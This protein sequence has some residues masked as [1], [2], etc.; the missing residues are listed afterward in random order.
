VLRLPVV[1]DWLRELPSVLPIAIVV[2][3][4]SDGTVLYANE[5]FG[6]LLAIG[7]EEAIGR[8]VVS[9]YDDPEE[10]AAV[11]LAVEREGQVVDREVRVRCADGRLVWVAVTV[12]PIRFAGEE[13]T[14]LT[15]IYDITR[16][17]RDEHLLT[18]QAAALAEMA[19]FPEMNP[20]PVCR[21]N[22]A[23][24]ILLANQATRHFFGE[25]KL[26]GR[27]WLEVCPGLDVAAWGRIVGATEWF[28]HEAEINGVWF[29]FAHRRD[30]DS[31]FVFGADV[32]D[33]KAAERRLRDYLET[34]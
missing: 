27:S 21:M 20:G 19:R 2:T 28:R 9:F 30:G 26:V 11:A 18:E 32:T 13:R 31:V 15:T 24:K 22:C 16:R 23:G 1:D 14:H 7:A 17:K 3:R 34:V 8:S 5:E 10:R 25:E 12:R 4:A 6:R 33:Q 29:V